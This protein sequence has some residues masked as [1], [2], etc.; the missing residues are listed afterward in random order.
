MTRV[1]KPL[2]R[3]LMVGA[4]VVGIAS[5]IVL[6]MSEPVPAYPALSEV[7]DPDLH[8]LLAYVMSDAGEGDDGFNPPCVHVVDL[9]TGVSVDTTCRD[10]FGTSLAW[11]EDGRLVVE[12][13]DVVQH[14]D[15]HFGRGMLLL[16]PLGGKD[17]EAVAYEGEA[18]LFW[19]DDRDRREDGTVLASEGGG[20]RVVI[21]HPDGSFDV[22]LP[23]EEAS[24]SYGIFVLQWSPDGRYVAGLDSEGRLIVASSTGDVRPRVAVMVGKSADLSFAWYIEGNPNYTIPLA[25]L[26]PH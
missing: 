15:P 4:L 20:S 5:L 8:G 2:S 14:R 19:P 13:D 6:T 23:V 3:L 11:T 22:L 10:S 9:A 26:L 17:P 1:A 7:T 24:P 12:D 18:E 21:R 25:A 16:D